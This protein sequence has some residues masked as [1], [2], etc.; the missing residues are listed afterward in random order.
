[1][2]QF[3]DTTISPCL[4]ASGG[5]LVGAKSNDPEEQVLREQLDAEKSK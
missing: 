1:M 5:E 2:K 3:I 4:A